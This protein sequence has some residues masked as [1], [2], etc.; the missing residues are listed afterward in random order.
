MKLLVFAHTP[1]PHHGQSYMVKLMLDGLGG[2][3]RHLA[4]GARPP[5]DIECYHVNCRYSDHFEDIGSVRL[6]K[7]WLVLRYCIE[8][9]WCRFRYG[10]TAFYYVPAPGK[11]AALYRDWITMLLCRP[12]FRHVIYHWHAVGLGDWLAREGHWWERRLTHWLLGQPIL[13]IALAIPSMRDAL[14]FRSQHVE[15]VP[16]GIPDPWPDYETAVRPRRE[17]RLAARSELLAGRSPA[18]EGRAGDESDPTV[19]RVLFLSHCTAEKGLFDTLDAMAM[20]NQTLRKSGAR[21]SMHL[22]VAGLF[23]NKTDEAA[24]HRRVAEED[25]AGTVTYAGFV[26]GEAKSRLLLE[27]DTLCFPTFY[28]AESFGLVLVEAMAA[29]MNVVATRWR[30]NADVLPIDYPGLVPVHAPEKIAQCLI[31]TFARDASALRDYVL[32][33]FTVLQSMEKL[34][35]V[36]RSVGS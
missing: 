3:R 14:W 31:R 7:M 35:A 4:P 26:S 36:L 11:R 23:V 19:L 34:H 25:L 22:T 20:A 9:I 27:C 18:V 33:N 10:A 24:F 13:G 21:W 32:Q 15:V 17:A 6:E 16:N 1:P 30:A 5:T 8:A 2:D 28:G 12:F 29:G